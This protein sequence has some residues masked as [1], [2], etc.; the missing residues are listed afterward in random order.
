MSIL[1]YLR[2]FWLRKIQL[3]ESIIYDASESFVC[4]ALSIIE[5]NRLRLTTSMNKCLYT[6][7]YEAPPPTET[8]C[9]QLT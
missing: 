9:L 3:Q 5:I 6:H 7:V 4:D 1:V 8:D 2:I